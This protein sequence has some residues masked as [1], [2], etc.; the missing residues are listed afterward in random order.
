MTA[1][2]KKKSPFLIVTLTLLVSLG[3]SAAAIAFLHPS[4]PKGHESESTSGIKAVLHLDP[5][6]VDMS[7]PGIALGLGHDLKGQDDGGTPT[8]LVRDT[9]LGVLMT[10]RPGELISSE[11]KQK[12]KE[13]ILNA[14]HR[15]APGFG[16]QEVYY[17]EFLMQQ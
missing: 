3:G 8:G 12:L 15:R 6:T 9:I 5:F 11:D 7:S 10:S 1:S 17:T 2:E 16:S 14:P 4:L 13:K